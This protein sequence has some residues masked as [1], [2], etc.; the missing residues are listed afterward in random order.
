MLYYYPT[1]IRGIVGLAIEIDI[2][3]TPIRG[4]VGSAIEIDIKV[5]YTEWPKIK[6]DK[7]KKSIRIAWEISNAHSL[8]LELIIHPKKWKRNLGKVTKEPSIR[9]N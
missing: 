5:A 8:S 6:Q 7:H 2:K 1:P 9:N 4:I 3:V